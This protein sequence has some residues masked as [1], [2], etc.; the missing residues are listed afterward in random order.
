M[1]VYTSC[2]RLGQAQM[3]SDGKAPRK[4]EV[5]DKRCSD[6]TSFSVTLKGFQLGD[7]WIL[8][9]SKPSWVNLL[10]DDK[11]QRRWFRGA[12]FP[13]L[14]IR[15]IVTVPRESRSR[16]DGRMVVKHRQSKCWVIHKKRRGYKGMWGRTEVILCLTSGWIRENKKQK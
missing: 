8:I 6:K 2:V 16:K 7:E 3:H 9:K 4:R 12:T 15:S 1:S 13:L 10:R 5:S 14:S 11:L